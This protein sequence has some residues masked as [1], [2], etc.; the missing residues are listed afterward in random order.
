[1]PV[2]DASPDAGLRIDGPAIGRELQLGQGS[3]NARDLQLRSQPAS[4][5]GQPSPDGVQVEPRTRRED[6]HI[7]DH[8]GDSRVLQF[9]AGDPAVQPVKRIIPTDHAARRNVRVTFRNAG[10]LPRQTRRRLNRRFRR[11]FGS[12]VSGALD[13]EQVISR[14]DAL[15]T[16]G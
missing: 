1:M 16:P 4:R 11:A 13:H 3:T 6:D 7:V 5:L 10:A 12:G 2:D 14:S 9:L 15:D 8:L